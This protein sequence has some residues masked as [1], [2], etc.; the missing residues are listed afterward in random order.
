MLMVVKSSNQG[1][2]WIVIVLRFSKIHEMRMCSLSLILS[3]SICIL[4]PKVLKVQ[5]DDVDGSQS[6]E[7]RENID[8]TTDHKDTHDVYVLPVTDIVNVNNWSEYSPKVWS[9]QSNDV[10]GGQVN[11]SRENIDFTTAQQYTGILYVLPVTDIVN[12]NV[13]PYLFQSFER[14]KDMMLMVAKSMNQGRA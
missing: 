5:R 4:S 7:W 3:M 10:D 14:C 2:T 13:N 11:E 12:V 6:N 8:C 1:R 9:L